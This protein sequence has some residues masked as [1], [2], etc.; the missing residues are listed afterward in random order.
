LKPEA[1]TGPES[2]ITTKVDVSS[3]LS[4]KLAALACHKTQLESDN[5][6]KHLTPALAKQFLGVEYFKSVDGGTLSPL[7]QLAI[8]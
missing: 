1:F 6:L 8:V 5:V 7:E 2:S 4:Q 3:V